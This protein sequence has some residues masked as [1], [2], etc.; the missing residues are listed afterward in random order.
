MPNL[1]LK[2]LFHLKISKQVEK[3]KLEAL[4]A[5]NKLKSMSENR[6]QQHQQLTAL[7]IEKKMEFERLRIHYESLLKDHEDQL[8][9]IEQF[10]LQK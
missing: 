10:M 4:G 7:V 2:F 6:K 5:R 3:E 1:H 8:E 9:F